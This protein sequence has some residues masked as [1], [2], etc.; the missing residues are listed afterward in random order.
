[1]DREIGSIEPGKMADLIGVDRDVRACSAAELARTQV[2]W[3][4]VSGQIVYR[5]SISDG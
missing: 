2:E 1:M 3:T 4:M 5:R